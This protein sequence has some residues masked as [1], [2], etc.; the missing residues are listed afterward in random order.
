MLLLAR[1][2][3]CLHLHGRSCCCCFNFLLGVQQ[4][5]KIWSPPPRLHFQPEPVHPHPPQLTFVP[6]KCYNFST[7]LYRFVIVRH[8]GLLVVVRSL[9][10]RKDPG[11]KSAQGQKNIMLH[12]LFTWAMNFTHICSTR[13]R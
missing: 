2:C 9:R 5:A 1:L 7:F 11:L 8:R 10:V 4:L 6:E 13:P 3:I 12:V